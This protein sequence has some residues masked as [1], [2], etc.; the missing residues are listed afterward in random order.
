MACAR[1]EEARGV[2]FY[3]I[4][5]LPFFFPF[6]FSFLFYTEHIIMFAGGQSRGVA[7]STPFGWNLNRG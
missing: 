2:S 6:F 3:L 1:E 7:V 4:L 5:I